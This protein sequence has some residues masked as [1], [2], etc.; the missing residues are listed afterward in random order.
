MTGGWWD[1]RIISVAN[2]VG[3]DVSFHLTARFVDGRGE[4]PQASFGFDHVALL[5]MPAD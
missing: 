4:V 3:K 5:E 1:D 2:L